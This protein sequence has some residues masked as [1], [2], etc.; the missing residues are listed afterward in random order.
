MYSSQLCRDTEN[1]RQKIGKV[2]GILEVH[3]VLLMVDDKY[4][5]NHKCEVLCGATFGDCSPNCIWLHLLGDRMNSVNGSGW[6]M[7]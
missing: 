5:L 4:N 6:S 1:Q 7:V 2:W 3:A